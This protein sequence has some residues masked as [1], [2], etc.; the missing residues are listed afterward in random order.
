MAAGACRQWMLICSPLRTNSRISRSSASRQVPGCCAAEKT[1]LNAW[2]KR[3]PKAP[4]SSRTAGACSAARARA[5]CVSV[6]SFSGGWRSVTAAWAAPQDQFSGAALSASPRRTSGRADA[7]RQASTP[8]S[9]AQSFGAGDC[10]SSACNQFVAGV[11]PPSTSRR[12][13]SG[14]GRW[15]FTCTCGRLSSSFVMGHAPPLGSL[16]RHADVFLRGV[17]CY[18][19]CS[20]GKG[21]RKFAGA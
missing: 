17:L 10:S 21:A 9:M 12:Q 5:S 7:L 2:S 18:N 4:V 1:V 19:Y 20:T 11:L 6:R 13:A 16:V 15:K 8:W 3:P 14:S